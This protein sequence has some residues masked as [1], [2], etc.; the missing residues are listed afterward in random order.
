VSH[1]GFAAGV[2]VGTMLGFFFF[3]PLCNLN[4]DRIDVLDQPRL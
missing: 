3:V 4:I 2:A 1:I